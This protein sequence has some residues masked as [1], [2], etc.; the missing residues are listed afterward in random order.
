MEK[1]ERIK[2]DKTVKPIHYS[3]RKSVELVLSVLDETML[4]GAN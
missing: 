2:V 1:W 4:L 3:K